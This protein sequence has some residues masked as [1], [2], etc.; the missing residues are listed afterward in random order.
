[1]S[2]VTSAIYSEIFTSIDEAKALKKAFA[3]QA[4]GRT[5]LLIS[6]LSPSP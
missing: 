1:M 6:L 4:G 3:L 2:S 5:G